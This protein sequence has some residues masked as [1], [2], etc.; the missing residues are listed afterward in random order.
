M[1]PEFFGWGFA[2]RIAILLPSRVVGQTLG[3]R[4][5]DMA[6]GPEVARRCLRFQTARSGLTQDWFISELW[7]QR[8]VIRLSTVCDLA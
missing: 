3:L 8:Q 4:G 5:L 1:K 7:G 2:D 6:R